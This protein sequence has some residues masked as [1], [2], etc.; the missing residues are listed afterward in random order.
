MVASNIK[1][2]VRV[3][4]S[5]R[6]SPAFTLP[7]D[8]DGAVAFELDNPTPDREVHNMKTSHKFRFDG[9]LGMSVTQEDVFNVVA[10]PVIEDVIS[11]VNGTIFAYGQT[12]SGKTF[13]ITGGAE[14][15][16]DRGLIPRTISHMF[17]AFRKGEAK[18]TM[19]ISYLE[20]YND[21]GY[22][23]LRDDN[24][25]K[26][27][28]LPK[29]TLR[30]DEDGNIHLRNLSVNLAG[31]EE[32]AL[33]L[34]FMGD[35]NRVVA[36]TPMNDA[37]TRSHCLFIIWVDSTKPGSDVVRR[38]KLHLV[39]L[40]GSE[41]VSK[42]GVEGNL[43]K[44][45]KYINLSLHYLEQVIVA[46]HER[47]KGSRN[48]VPYRNSMMTSVLRDSLGGNC[49]TTM[50]GCVAVESS[51]ISE[52]ISTCRFA[53]RVATIQNN[54]TVNEELDPNLLIARLKREVAELREEVRIAKSGSEEAFTAEDAEKCR[55]MVLQYVSKHNDVNEPFV[56]ASVDRLRVSF[57]ILRDMCRGVAEGAQDERNGAAGKA[58]GGGAASS[59]QK[60]ALEAQVQKLRLEVA[61][62]DQEIGV[63]VQMLSK[64]RGGGAM[65][66]VPVQPRHPLSA[67][68]QG[69]SAGMTHA[70]A[71]PP[72][73]GNLSPQHQ[74]AEVPKA[75]SANVKP[76]AAG[77]R[78]G[79]PRHTAA[80]SQVILP[81]GVEAAD[82]LLDPQRAFEVYK[83][84][85]CAPE[86]FEDNKTLL[87]QRIAAAKAIGN[88]A[89]SVRG[90]ISSAKTRL[91]KLRTTKAMTAAGEV[92]GATVLEDGPEEQ[93]E[94]HEI[95]RLKGIYRE[96]TGELRSVKG[97]I[98][99]IQGML[100]QIKKRRQREFETWFANLRK[101]TSLED[102][103][104]EKKRELYEKV[105]AG[106][107][108][109]ASARLTP[110]ASQSGAGQGAPLQAHASPTAAGTAAA[111]ARAWR[112]SGSTSRE[113]SPASG[114]G[115][116]LRKETPLISH[117]NV[118]NAQVPRPA[119]ASGPPQAASPSAE[120]MISVSSAPAKTGDGQLDDEIAAYFAALGELSKR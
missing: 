26:L 54:A 69:G 105:V 93:A 120:T 67:V 23:L 97:D 52:A 17:D 49:K 29:V 2:Y 39:D 118:Q 79:I 5:G 87:Q 45:A 7:Q 22:D 48:H 27:E 88:E 73:A 12:G 25:S 119:S 28:D 106:P 35:T 71:V 3:R 11:G 100:E 47:T 116:P 99:R 65:G 16:A 81:P 101:K 104:D 115:Q 77:P 86:S 112:S 64:A 75:S 108:A 44:E 62:R 31:T 33:N 74:E 92:D 1:V 80:R 38:S 83:Q 20:I 98:E 102:M 56:C 59:A 15:Y 19:Y 110:A 117:A 53:Q 37:S 6:P 57:R 43:L 107:S 36:E 50:V 4:P 114:R 95:E 96:K 76:D 24:A 30:E 90:L 72:L 40:A 13:T 82:L 103:E 46:L 41:R 60:A 14:R 55:A 70:A 9:I 94:L 42:T 21:A 68:G 18:S 61:Q 78:R 109:P 10:K 34:L 89:N 91:E 32:D 85:A 8:Q 111:V 63:L 51:N 58:R 84:I 113:P 66:G